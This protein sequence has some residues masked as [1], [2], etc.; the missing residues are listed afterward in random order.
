MIRLK[1][2]KGF[3]LIELVIVILVI[4]VLAA[5]ILPKFV[6]Q[7]EKAKIATTKANLESLRS[8]TRL[9]YSDNK[10]VLPATGAA[11]VPNY[12]KRIPDEAITSSTTVVTANDGTG[13]WVYTAADGDWAIN[14]TGTDDNGDGYANY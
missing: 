9:Y 1:G 4:G 2:K 13:G 12:I 10:G 7:V 5:V 8:A 11:L 14:L 6:G 3:T